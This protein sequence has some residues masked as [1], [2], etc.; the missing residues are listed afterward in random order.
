MNAHECIQKLPI[1]LLNERYEHMAKDITDIK[2]DVSELKKD[3]SIVKEFILTSPQ[4]FADKE[5]T[6]GFMN[7]INLKL[8]FASWIITIVTW[9]WIFI[10]NKLF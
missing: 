7:W 1:G 2:S 3:F 5:K 4:K 8:A 9:V 10:A 6:E